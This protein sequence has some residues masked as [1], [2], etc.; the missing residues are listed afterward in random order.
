MGLVVL[1]FET[2]PYHNYSV[3]ASQSIVFHGRVKA[4]WK[5]LDPDGW[6]LLFL[7]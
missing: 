6:V 4:S 7:F 2:R 5:Q 1:D 3:V